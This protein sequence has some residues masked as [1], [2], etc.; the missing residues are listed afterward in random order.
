MKVVNRTGCNEEVSTVEVS[1][2]VSFSVIEGRALD[3]GD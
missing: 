2:S 3:R 1:R